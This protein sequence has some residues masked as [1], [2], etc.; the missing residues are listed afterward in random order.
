M[1]SEMYLRET[2]S[3]MLRLRIEE[4][5]QNRRILFT[6][7]GNSRRVAMQIDV[8]RQVFVRERSS[9][10]RIRSRTVQLHPQL[11]EAPKL[12]ELPW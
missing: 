6:V 4:T 9:P 5:D 8:D 12:V 2:Q 7:G 3:M 10:G 11:D 1:K